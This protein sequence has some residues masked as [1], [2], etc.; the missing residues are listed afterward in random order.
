[1][2]EANERRLRWGNKPCDHREVEIDRDDIG[3]STGDYVCTQ[4]GKEGTDRDLTPPKG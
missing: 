2:R 4:C 3:T 1:M